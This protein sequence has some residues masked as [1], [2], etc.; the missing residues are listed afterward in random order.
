MRNPPLREQLGLN[1]PWDSVCPASLNVFFFVLCW[2]SFWQV[3][4][5]QK[6][7]LSWVPGSF[8]TLENLGLRLRLPIIKFLSGTSECTRT[9]QKKKRGGG[10]ASTV[11]LLS[12]GITAGITYLKA[13]KAWLMD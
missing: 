6:F 1:V 13:F 10:L 7:H 4:R 3:S 2:D 12:L 9:L 8:L 11:H 5:L